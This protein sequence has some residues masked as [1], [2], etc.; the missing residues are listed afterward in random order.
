M[1]HHAPDT[2]DLFA[3]P[4]GLDLGARWTGLHPIGIEQD[5]NACATRRAAGLPT[6]HG[7]VRDYGPDDFPTATELQQAADTLR[8][9]P[10]QLDQALAD[11]LDATANA[12]ACLAPF[13]D[14]EP[15]Y[16]MW[17]A[18]SRVADLVNAE[19]QP[20]PAEAR[21]S[22]NEE[23][24]RWRRKAIRRVLRLARFEGAFQAVQDLAADKTLAA[25]ADWQDGYQQAIADLRELLGDAWTNN[26]DQEGLRP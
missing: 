17:N 19:Q 25:S 2:I 16:S 1:T 4:G 10:A 7:D 5:R 13:R 26:H 24:K 23:T 22:D 15:G 8:T 3:G 6:I 11:W 9:R 18:A 21:T 20:E 14:H 12:L